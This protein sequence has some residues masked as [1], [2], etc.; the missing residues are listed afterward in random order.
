MILSQFH[1]SNFLSIHLNCILPSPAWSSNMFPTNILY[2]FLVSP[3]LAVCPAHLILL[4]I[5]TLTILGALHMLVVIQC[6]I[7]LSYYIFLSTSNC[8]TLFS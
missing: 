4:D 5:T 7:L 6:P 8:V 2:A 1:P 3:I